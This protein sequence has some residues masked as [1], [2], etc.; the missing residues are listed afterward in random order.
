MPE[1]TQPAQEP[2]NRYESSALPTLRTR[3]RKA[4][5][6]PQQARRL[7]ARNQLRQPNPVLHH[8]AVP[9]DQRPPHQDRERRRP[10]G[11]GRRSR[12]LHSRVSALPPG[13]GV[14]APSFSGT[15][16]PVARR[17][18]KYAAKSHFHGSNRPFSLN[19]RPF[20]A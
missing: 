3:T 9:A 2:R 14:I 10:E 15:T 4:S 19:L 11:H 20:A 7:Q 18:P 17:R 12:P 16:V 1:R 5:R 6:R 13:H 8:A